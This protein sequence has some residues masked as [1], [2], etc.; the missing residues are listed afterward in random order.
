ML[1]K[2]LEEFNKNIFDE[3]GNKWAILV[4]GDRKTGYNGMTISWGTVGI[5]WNKPVFFAFVRKSRYT[6]KF[7]EESKNI[8]LSFL[9]DKYKK[10]KAFFGSKSGRDFDKFKETGLHA[11]LDLDYNGYYVA[12]AEYVLKGTKITS[13]DLKYDDLPEEIKKDFYE[14]RD[15]HTVYVCEIKQYLINETL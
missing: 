5:L 6:H 8:T 4:A 3:I 9:S 10:E 13:F 15:E 7:T 11:T 14:T 1:K 2:S 12:E